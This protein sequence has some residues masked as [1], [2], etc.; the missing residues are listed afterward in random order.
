[1]S[2]ELGRR[3]GPS[4]KSS[5]CR[6]HQS[7][8]PSCV[9]CIR[10]LRRDKKQSS[11][12]ANESANIIP[13]YSDVDDISVVVVGLVLFAWFSRQSVLETESCV[14]RLGFR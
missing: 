5:M 14:A 10:R 4:Y 1:M 8:I 2:S 7:S 13:V 12:I 9:D 3:L 6:L 11:G